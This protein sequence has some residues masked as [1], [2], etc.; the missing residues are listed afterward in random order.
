MSGSGKIG[1]MNGK[2]AGLFRFALLTYPVIL[3]C[4]LTWG[5]WVTVNILK[6]D[7]RL[8]RV[9]EIGN[10]SVSRS[11]AELIKAATLAVSESRI[12]STMQTFNK[13]VMDINRDIT[14][15]K[16]G[17]AALSAEIKTQNRGGHE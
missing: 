6:F 2:F 10:S 16:V 11:D 8:M 9:E 1:E 14:E 13:T 4:L 15:I 3:T 12:T 7:G 17:V 5:T